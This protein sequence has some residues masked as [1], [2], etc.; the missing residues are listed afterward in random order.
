MM[1][2]PRYGEPGGMAFAYLVN[3]DAPD[4]AIVYAG[5]MVQAVTLWMHRTGE[6]RMPWSIRHM[7]DNE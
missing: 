2:P 6:T 1:F 5:D 7:A 4:E 3:E